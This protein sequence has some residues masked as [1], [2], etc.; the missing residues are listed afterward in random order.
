[1]L[2]L[3]VAAHY[4]LIAKHISRG[5]A[6]TGGACRQRLVDAISGPI[7]KRTD[8]RVTGSRSVCRPLADGQHDCEDPV[9]VGC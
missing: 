3:G 9:I 8:C 6:F 4:V 7:H 2:H 5:R 1:V